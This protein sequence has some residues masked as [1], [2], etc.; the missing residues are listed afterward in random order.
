MNLETR[1]FQNDIYIYK[2]LKYIYTNLN[3]PTLI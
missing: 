2:N 3:Y 1:G